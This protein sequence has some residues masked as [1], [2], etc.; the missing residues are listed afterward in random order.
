M[1]K[2]PRNASALLLQSIARSVGHELGIPELVA[3]EYMAQYRNNL[4][5]EIR[6][7]SKSHDNLRRMIPGWIESGSLPDAEKSEHRVREELEASFAIIPAPEGAYK[8][9]MLRETRRQEPAKTRGEKPG[10]GGRDVVV[11]LTALSYCQKTQEKVFFI[12]ANKHDFGD[13][14]LKPALASEMQDALR[15]CAGS[16]HYYA[17][18]ESFL[19]EVEEIEAYTVSAAQLAESGKVLEA[20]SESLDKEVPIRLVKHNFT[21][22]A[23]HDSVSD[24]EVV[25]VEKIAGSR[26]SVSWT[27]TNKGWALVK[28]RWQGK[29]EFTGS[30]GEFGPDATRIETWF[31][32]DIVLLME[33]SEGVDMEA[34]DVVNVGPYEHLHN[35]YE[36]LAPPLGSSYFYQ[37]DR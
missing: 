14:E 18:I 24:L 5:A 22:I 15:S 12:S 29:Q 9:G 20:V 27:M 25:S 30:Y 32:V 6:G 34:V 36:M 26:Q 17:G 11:W 37:S 4:D 8:E 16:F 10:S 33:L 7:L 35:V 13:N 21:T 3:E 28:S 1:L 23:H 19:G 2:A 31:K